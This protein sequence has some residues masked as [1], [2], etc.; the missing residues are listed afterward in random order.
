MDDNTEQSISKSLETR[1]ELLPYLPELLVDLWALGS[2]PDLIV[3]I[4]RPL[5]LPSSSTRALDL[6]CGKGAVSITLA[7]ELG[8]RVVGI[9]ACKAFLE[10]AERKA[11]EFNVS[12][13]CQFE[14]G[15]IRK[16]IKAAENFDIAVYASMGN[17]L[18]SFDECV[19]KLRGTIRPGG[20]IVIDDG[21]LENPIII[22]RGGYEHYLPHD[23]T[24]KQLT[25]QGNTLFQ[26]L[27]LTEE[28]TRSINEHY[29]KAMRR[30]AQTLIQRHP[31]LHETIP[32]YIREQAI[33]C[34]LI[35]K[36]ITG[37]IWLLKRA[38]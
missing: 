1:P 7:R 6:G 21:F 26:E 30:R 35:E 2:S 14:F 28:E 25:S 10:E 29:I 27:L 12:E 33:E 8:F 17:V 4:L 22:K 36:H 24:L 9:D 23:E 3:E 38:E 11:A 15:D 13:L 31:H 5:N 34:E 32:R 37:A 16:S 19:G 18:G 20:Y